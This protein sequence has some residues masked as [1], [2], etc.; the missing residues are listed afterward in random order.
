MHYC[1]AANKYKA[2]RAGVLVIYVDPAYT[3]KQCSGCGHIDK[4][5]RPNQA[6][7]LCTSCGLSLSADWNAAINISKRGQGSWVVSHATARD[8]GEAA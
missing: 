2:I 6:T 3:S 7:F 8:T 5:N 1:M 4:K